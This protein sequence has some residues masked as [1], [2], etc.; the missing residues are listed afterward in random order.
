MQTV[1]V[2][3]EVYELSVKAEDPLYAITDSACS[4]SVMGTGWMQRY[5]EMAK[6]MGLEVPIVH[7]KENFKFGASRVYES[8][9]AGIVT[10]VIGN[11]W[12][13]VKAAVVHGEVPLLI[14][15]P[16]LASIGTILDIANNMATFTA[17]GVKNLKLIETASGHPAVL[18]G[19]HGLD[20]PS[21]ESLPKAWDAKEIAIL[22]PCR[23]Y[24]SFVAEGVGSEAPMCRRL[25]PHNVKVGAPRVF[26]EK[27]LDPAVRN[28]LIADTLNLNSFLAWWSSTPISND[29]WIECEDR[30]VRVHVVPRKY[31]FDPSS[32]NTPQSH[33]RESLLQSLGDVR[34]SWGISCHSYRMFDALGEIWRS[35]RSHAFP[36]LWVGRSTFSR[37]STDPGDVC[38]MEDEQDRAAAGMCTPRNSDELQVDSGRAPPDPHRRQQESAP[39]TP[40]PNRVELD[41][42]GATSCRGPESGTGVG[43][44]RHPRDTHAPHPGPCGSRPDRNDPGP[45]QRQL[46]QGYTGPVR[47]LGFG[48]GEGKPDHASRSA[49]LCDMEASQEGVPGED[50]LGGFKIRGGPRGRFNDTGATLDGDRLHQ[51]IM[52]HRGPRDVPTATSAYHTVQGKGGTRKDNDYEYDQAS[53]ED[54]SPRGGTPTANGAG[55]RTGGPHGDRDAGTSIGR[56]PRPA[57]TPPRRVNSEE[58]QTGGRGKGH[59]DAVP[60]RNEIYHNKFPNAEAV[61]VDEGEAK[62][63]RSTRADVDPLELDENY[64]EEIYMS[65]ESQDE[66]ATVSKEEILASA[67]EVHVY[68]TSGPHEKTDK[69][70][71]EEQAAR[72]AMEEGD[73]TYERLERV[74]QATNLKAGRRV[75]KKVHGPETSERYV[76]GLYGYGPFKGI[77]RETLGRPN[78]TKY[79]NEFLRH[80]LLPDHGQPTW[81]SFTIVRNAKGAMHVDANN[82]VD[83]ENYVTGFGSYEGGGVWVQET[84]GGTW[85]RHPNGEEIEGKV[86]DIYHKTICFGPKK[87]HMGEAWTGDRYSLIAYTTRT[88]FEITKSERT[89]MISLGFPMPEKSKRRHS[90]PPPTTRR[91]PRRSTRKG[92]WK[93]AAQLSSVL[94]TITVALQNQAE[95]HAITRPTAPSTAIM[96]VGG[97][98][99]SCE[100]ANALGKDATISEPVLWEDMADTEIFK[101]RSLAMMCRQQAPS[102]LRVHLDQGHIETFKEKV[103]EAVNS[104]LHDGRIV[105]FE[106]D[107]DTGRL[108][109]ECKM[110]WPDYTTE[111]VRLDDDRECL[112]IQPWT[113]AT[114]Y[115]T[116]V[117][118]PEDT[119][120]QEH[121]G[122]RGIQLGRNVPSHVASALKRLHQNLGHPSQPDFVRHL[123]LAGAS[124]A[125]L[126]AAKTLQCQT[127]TRT[128]AT[129]IAKPAAVGNFLQFNQVIGAD[130]IYAHDTNGVKHEL[131]SLVDFSSSY[132]VVIPVPRKNATVLEAALC[133]HWINVFGTPGTI[134]VDLENGLQKA[135]GRIGD[136]TGMKIRS[137][138]GQAHYQAGFTERQGGIWKAI[139]QRINEE[140]NV[141][142][143][144]MKIAIAATSSAKNELKKISGYSPSQHV[145]GTTR[146]LPEDLIDGPAVQNPGDEIFVGDKH[147]R[148]VAIRT[149]ARAAFH[150]VQVDQQVRRA[151]HGRS[152]VQ[153]RDIQVGEQAFY[154]RKFKNSKRGAWHGPC[155]VIGREGPNYWVSRNGRCVMVA[156][157]HIRA[158]TPEELGE[159][160]NLRATKA[161]LD[162]LLERD[163]ED[164]DAFE[165]PDAEMEDTYDQG[166]DDLDSGVFDPSID[167]EMDHVVM[168]ELPEPDPR[169]V[170][171]PPAEGTDQVAKRYRRKAPPERA[172]PQEA[173]MLKKAKTERSRNKQL[174]KEIPWHMIPEGQKQLFKAAEDKQWGEHISHR[175]LEP[176]S[177]EETEAVLKRVPKDRILPCRYAYKD[178]NLGARRHNPEVPCKPKA[179]LVIGGHLDPD[180]ADENLFMK[181]DSPTVSRASLISLLQIGT[182]RRWRAAA[183]D[184]QAA[185]LNGLEIDR[186]LYMWQPRCGVRGLHPAQLIRIRKGIFGLAESPRRWFDRLCQVLLQHVFILGGTECQLQPCPLDPCVFMAIPTANKKEPC[187]YLAVHVD[188]ILVI[189]PDGINQEIRRELSGLFPVD[190]W[191]ED[192]FEYVGSRI[193]FG[194]EGTTITQESFVE[195]RLFEVEVPPTQADEEPAT[196]EQI[197]DN[198]SLIG[199]LSWLASQTRPDLQ[200]GV[201][202]AQQL[203]RA[204]TAGDIRFTNG[205]AKKA[206]QHKEQGIYLRPIPLEEG[207]YY[208]FHDAAWANAYLEDVDPEF[209]LYDEDKANGLMRDAPES[210]LKDRKARRQNSKVASQ[211]G[212]VIFFGEAS[213]L[214]GDTCQL[215]TLEWRSQAC[216]RVCRSTFGAETMACVEAL[217]NT[218]FL[219]A[220]MATLL[221][222]HLI[223]NEIAKDRWPILCVSDCKSL[224]DHLHRTGFPR[225][226]TDRRLALDLAALRQQL[227][228][229]K[230]GQR[231]PLQWIPN[232]YQLADVLTKPVKATEWWP[233]V[234]DGMTL[235]FREDTFESFQKESTLETS[236]DVKC[237]DKV[238]SANLLRADS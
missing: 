38:A 132:H 4:K 133:D 126:K 109:D 46:L 35:A 117:T 187:A 73:F 34:E 151:L 206:R 96:E 162:R 32:W 93:R 235:P 64:D 106:K 149:A 78:F 102:E 120:P 124:P 231:V 210:I 129:A 90:P 201:A 116:E 171:R 200:C 39:G 81:S 89:A 45:L 70:V 228:A 226:P 53:S 20:K 74:L 205:L 2:V 192:N 24:T 41:E 135:F 199:A 28:M 31:T 11:S 156:P 136:W 238:S 128:K 130:L 160:F 43:C 91:T 194:Q 234:K 220:L 179:R 112:R 56:T 174:E 163:Y 40:E 108:W 10:F 188:D 196:D 107:H 1:N 165:E 21:P 118:N 204:P 170:R 76:F 150:Q 72:D 82:M 225:I 115:P 218:Q 217:E 222:G 9:Y 75:R 166:F 208:T 83:S 97:V 137:C 110:S 18:I 203:Q 168:E 198:R 16:A 230:W 183:G 215:S 114:A 213:T 229:E 158:A 57:W 85:R 44:P 184:V 7:E 49:A 139:F 186:E 95:A 127:C 189:A 232:L 113:T 98:T 161:D 77:C 60:P 55:D 138:A 176:L 155:S 202:L 5:V 25:V 221:E 59:G 100:A 3:H 123:R 6:E 51:R 87:L 169:G 17:L 52:G 105:V 68:L 175:A 36:T 33:V 54:E 154:Y 12:V 193:S 224:H 143:A 144:E 227:Q 101:D 88:A 172:S 145:F 209:M 67:E 19:S 30:L 111:T 79:L 180:L 103:W 125:I 233:K 47:G 211:I 164:D 42:P 119:P 157:E 26:F 66:V 185:F 219:R 147:A 63:S 50:L 58:P 236:V 212:H 15:R 216:Q 61:M 86:H 191:M 69:I 159:V 62:G 71:E 48:R 23:A 8:N 65:C 195:G 146:N 173:N 131:L 121:D 84:G 207:V 99:A 92:L 134:A 181:T 37:A 190:D 27:R 141:T 177:L 167:E 104:Q 152:R 13:A 94:A 140:M 29:F 223:K 197:I 214:K 14:S 80:H 237:F 153:A 22:S 142:Q 122:A 178:K 148:E 182:S